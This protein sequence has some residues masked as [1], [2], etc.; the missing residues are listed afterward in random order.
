MP[1]LNVR[2]VLDYFD[3]E[4]IRDPAG[5][6][7]KLLKNVIENSQIYPKRKIRSI[8]LTFTSQRSWHGEKWTH[9]ARI[10]VPD[11]YKMEGK[12]GIIGTNRNFVPETN[13]EMG[14]SEHFKRGKLYKTEIKTE[15]EFCE[16]TALDL[17]IPIMIFTNPG[18]KIF[19]LEEGALM[20]YTLEKIGETEDM[21][22]YGYG[23]ITYAYLRAITL[24]SSL[25]ELQAKKAVLFGHSK[26]GL[27]SSIATRIDPERI[28][29][30]I[31]SGQGGGNVLHYIATK[32]S[33]FGN[34][35]INLDYKATGPG[36]VPASTNL[37]GM[38]S[39][40]GFQSILI[41]DP[42]MWRDEIKVPTMIVLGSN[43][44]L[45]G[46]EAGHGMYPHLNC[47]KALVT[48]ENLPHTWA[49]S[50]ILAAWRVWLGHIFFDR[51]IPK[52]QTD[53]ILSKE[54]ITIS[55]EVGG[56]LKNIVSVRIFHAH[57]KKNDWRHIH[58][59]PIEIDLTDGKF[60]K[61]LTLEKERNF[62]Y[63]VEVEDSHTI[64]GSG[65]VSTPVNLYR[66]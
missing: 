35:T 62:G 2:S 47:D 43:D 49:A 61:T 1:Q 51:K 25:P 55:G 36:F 16:R 52:I 24:L 21:S 11:N 4:K 22:W 63:F 31:N 14:E 5:L 7:I 46:A 44:E 10:Y 39:P 28:A 59:I 20:G 65:Y 37:M 33:E 48:V 26:R 41:W 18:S 9:R 50:K 57:N 8:H 40:L 29:G 58:W 23:A 13:Y 6:D 30:V 19:G 15:P 64:T 38:N 42:Y 54:S 56:D 60:S 34:R 27:A 17:G 12:V 3:L 45:L 66:Y 53:A 32:F